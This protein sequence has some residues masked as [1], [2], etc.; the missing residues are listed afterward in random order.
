MPVANST[1]CCS[2]EIFGTTCSTNGGATTAKGP[3]P[4]APK[5]V[6]PT[7]PTLDDWRRLTPKVDVNDAF[8]A[9]G[10]PQGF[11]AH[12][13]GHVG[14]GRLTLAHFA[15]AIFNGQEEGLAVFDVEAEYQVQ[16]GSSSG[17]ELGLD[18]MGDVT[19]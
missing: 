1:A 8:A 15:G 7:A 9:L 4:N 17:V 18:V 3:A 5:T 19:N 11:G 2:A 12:D 13:Q 14:V 6:V 10:P 16:A